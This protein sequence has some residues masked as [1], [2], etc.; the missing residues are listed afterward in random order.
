VY[1]LGLTEYAAVSLNAAAQSLREAKQDKRS[2]SV[3]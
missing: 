2:P 3:R 1:P